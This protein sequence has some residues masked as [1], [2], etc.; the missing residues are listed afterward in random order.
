MKGRTERT[1]LILSYMI[2]TGYLM[3]HMRICTWYLQLSWNQFWKLFKDSQR[4]VET[5]KYIPEHLSLQL[6]QFHCYS[7]IAGQDLPT[8]WG[9]QSAKC[10]CSRM[11]NRTLYEE[12]LK[13]DKT[14][15]WQEEKIHG[16]SV[17]QCTI[18]SPGYWGCVDSQEHPSSQVLW[19]CSCQHTSSLDW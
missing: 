8:C 10:D 3:Y 16:S 2:F 15:G 4:S 12:L 6:S 14:T 13:N 9:F 17:L 11:K 19:S 18:Y 1:C 7:D 5:M